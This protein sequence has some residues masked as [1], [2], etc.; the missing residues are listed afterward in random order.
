MVAN[1]F[2]LSIIKKKPFQRFKTKT[3]VITE[4]FIA[5]PIFN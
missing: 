4:C 1:M 2:N 5:K 3:D